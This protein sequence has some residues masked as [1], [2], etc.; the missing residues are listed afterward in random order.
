M[1]KIRVLNKSTM[2]ITVPFS[3][4]IPE[5]RHINGNAGPGEEASCVFGPPVTSG[6]A[7]DAVLAW[8]KFQSAFQGLSI[9]VDIGPFLEA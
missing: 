7:Q 4:L 8:A 5:A 9:E 2:A 3:T 6:Q 1:L